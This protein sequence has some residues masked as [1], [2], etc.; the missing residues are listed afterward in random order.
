VDD[1]PQPVLNGRPRPHVRGQTPAVAAVGMPEAGTVRCERT[2][3]PQHLFQ[4]AT[5]A[6]HVLNLSQA[7]L[8]AFPPVGCAQTATKE[9]ETDGM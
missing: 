4:A 7:A 1:A 3:R 9:R 8:A 2:V 5:W 6:G